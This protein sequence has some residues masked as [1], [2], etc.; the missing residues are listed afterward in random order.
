LLDR[1]KTHEAEAWQR[2]V[3]LYGPMVYGWCRRSG[4]QAEDAE[5]LLQEV[6][7]SVAMHV[8]D[9]RHDRP[10]D[11]FRAWL[12]EITRNKI[13]N[14]FRDKAGQ[15][16]APGGSDAQQRLSQILD[17]LPDA[18]SEDEQLKEESGLIRLASQMIRAEFE[19]RT[20]RAFYYTT[21][22][23]RP[24]A[25]VAAE[26]GMSLQAVYKAKSRVLQ[27]LRQELLE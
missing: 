4:V 25:E 5:D 3:K 2:L 6:L 1:L 13:C 16:R 14:F 22:D 18:P 19:D 15:V 17:P 23:C 11:S 20:W 26:L 10:G 21:V 8:A 7:R 24:G 12:R 27:R 9:F